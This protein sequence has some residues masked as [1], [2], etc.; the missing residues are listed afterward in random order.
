MHVFRSR[1]QPQ[2]VASL[3][4]VALI[5]AVTRVTRGF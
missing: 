4:G 1:N 3:P 2:A 5:R